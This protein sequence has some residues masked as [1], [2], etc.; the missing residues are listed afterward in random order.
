MTNTTV[1]I[2]KVLEFFN[3]IK[4]HRTKSPMKHNPA[5]ISKII[6]DLFTI[7]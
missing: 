4:Q 2:I 3:G 7:L 6:T 5:K 1:D